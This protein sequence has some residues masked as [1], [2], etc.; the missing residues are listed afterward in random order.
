MLLRRKLDSSDDPAE[1]EKLRR[2]LD[3]YNNLLNKIAAKI[4]DIEEGY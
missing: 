1:Q 4:E 3:Y 2:Q